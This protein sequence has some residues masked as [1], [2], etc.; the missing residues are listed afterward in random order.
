MPAGGKC[1]RREKSEEKEKSE[2]VHVF[3]R[4]KCYDILDKKTNRRL[5]NVF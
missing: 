3:Y 2:I 4:I 1:G 5:N